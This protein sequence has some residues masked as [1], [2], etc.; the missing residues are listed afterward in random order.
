MKKLVYVDKSSQ[1]HF[2]VSWVGG[3]LVR[4]IGTKAISAS[5]S[6]KVKAKLGNKKLISRKLFEAPNCHFGLCSKCDVTG[7]KGALIVSYSWY[8]I[9]NF[10]IWLGCVKMELSNGCGNKICV[11]VACFMLLVNNQKIIVKSILLKFELKLIFDH[12]KKDHI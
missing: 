3:W 5:T 6:V 2:S 11:T 4:S 7:G 1:K 9:L 12:P 8:T 10:N